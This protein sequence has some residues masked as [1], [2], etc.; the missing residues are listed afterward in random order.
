M[1]RHE[2]EHLLRAAGAVTDQKKIIVIGSQSV[3]GSV[4]DAPD[5]LLMSMEADMYPAEKPELA[6]IIDGSIGELSPFEKT[7]GYYAQGVGP[8]TAILPA[9]WDVRTVEIHN[10]NTD[11]V[12]GMCLEPHDLAASKLADGR[13]KDSVFVRAMLKHQII[14]MN[15]LHDRISLLPV[16]E[17]RKVHL[18]KIA[19]SLTK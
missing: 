19:E 14:S 9:G 1:R 17:E 2:L 13:E 18:K 3:L 16:D 12:T 8:E 10:R 4:P 5:E 6:D 7:F 11:G 15:K